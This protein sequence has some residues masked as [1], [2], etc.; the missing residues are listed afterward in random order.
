MIE[1]GHEESSRTPGRS[2]QLPKFSHLHFIS[3][4]PQAFIM[5]LLPLTTPPSSSSN[6]FPRFSQDSPSLFSK[7]VPDVQWSCIEGPCSSGCQPHAFHTVMKVPGSIEKMR[8]KERQERA[9]FPNTI[10]ELIPSAQSWFLGVMNLGLE[11]KLLGKVSYPLV[12]M[13]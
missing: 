7:P 6:H 2:S 4:L 10:K 5:P 13:D 12:K 3:G 8:G 9:P 11:L 1:L